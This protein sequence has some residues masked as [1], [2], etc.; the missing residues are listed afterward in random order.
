MR[1][2]RR[3]FI[4]LLAVGGAASALGVREAPAASPPRVWETRPS[5]ASYEPSGPTSW[6]PRLEINTANLVWNLRQIQARVGGKAVMAVVKANA[7]GHGLVGVARALAAA[8]VEHFLTGKLAEA[9]QLRAAGVHGLILNFGPFRDA[10]AE[11]VIRLG[12]SQNVYTD[13]VEALN[14]AARRR[15]QPARV[16]IKV[17]TGLGR[18][19]VPHDRAL[20]FIKRVAALRGVAFDGIFTTFTEEPE[21]DPI[22]LARFQAI[23]RR[24]AERGLSLG[25]RH[26]ASSDAILSLPAAYTEFDIVR[27][28]IMLYGLYPSERA[29]QERKIDLKP[30]LALKTRVAYVKTLRPGE[31]VSYHRV[32]TASEPERVATLPVGY[33]DG[34]PR[35][36]EGKGSVLVA[37]RRCRILAISANATIV[38][39]GAAPAAPGDEAV[40]LGVQGGEEVTASEV[41]GLTGSSVYGVVMGMSGLL[42]QVYL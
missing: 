33:S 28:G 6:D 34:F 14:R 16:H 31:S 7:Y 2:N 41:A 30:V 23:C 29:E 20:E 39:L 25:L 40:L 38:R 36:L 9:R 10:D 11:E 26:A 22:Q 37:G 12:I 1:V 8:G 27:P 18:V 3:N 4:E 32:F 5:A 35:A 13:Q 19:G 21:F 42:P 15:N 24:A 17:D